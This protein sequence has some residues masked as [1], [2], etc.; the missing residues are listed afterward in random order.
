[1]RAFQAHEMWW[2][3]LDRSSVRFGNFL[4]ELEEEVRP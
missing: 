1:M 2:L 3:K 4:A